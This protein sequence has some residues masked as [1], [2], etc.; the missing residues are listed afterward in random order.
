MPINEIRTLLTI[1]FLPMK[2]FLSFTLLFMTINVMNVVGSPCAAQAHKDKTLVLYYSQGGATSRVAAELSNLLGSEMV[3]VEMVNPY[4]DAYDATLERCRQ[5]RE[6]GV[7]PDVLPVKADLGEYDTIFL[8][9]PIWFGTYALPIASMLKNE[10]FDNK[11]IIP[12][13]TFGS[14]G[15]ESSIE[16]LKKALPKA[17]IRDGYGVRN[18]RLSAMPKELRRFLIE[19][20]YME[21]EI[22][23][24][25]DYQDEHA[26]TPADVETFNA[27][28]SSYKFPL[29]TPQSVASRVTPDGTDYRFVANAVMPNGESGRFTIYVTIPNE[30]AT[31]EFTRVVR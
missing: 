14:G 13:C 31:A 24:L 23:P 29:G 18:A 7:T 16:D 20:G 17:D 21:G 1:I 11:T 10:N 4:D 25:P 15:L 30:T 28:C 22:A 2:N 3:A 8:G 12:F 5:E 6:A 26:V 27:A 9:Y 19:N